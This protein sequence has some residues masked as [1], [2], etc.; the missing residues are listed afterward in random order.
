MAITTSILKIQ[1]NSRIFLI[2]KNATQEITRIENKIVRNVNSNIIEQ[3]P[4]R[5]FK[6]TIETNDIPDFGLLGS[7]KRFTIYS[8]V[9]L[10]EHKKSL[11][12]IPFVADSLQSFQTA[13]RNFI[14]FRPI[15]EMQLVSFK[16]KSGHT[17]KNHW[18]LEF[19]EP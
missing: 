10:I 12:S 19:E 7:N 16:T 13:S 14:K 4:N 8:I 15:F 2:S 5:K 11:P 9:E 1:A 3:Q 18:L 6:T 17:Q